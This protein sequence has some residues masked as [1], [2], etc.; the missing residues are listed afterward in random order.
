MV[1][2]IILALVCLY[3][4]TSE[5]V[6]AQGWRGIVP[7]HSTRQEVEALLGFKS[8]GEGYDQF[9]VSTDVVY[10]RYTSK[11]CEREEVGG[12]DVPIGTVSSI[13]VLPQSKVTF[14]SL[15]LDLNKFNVSRTD[16]KGLNIYTNKEDGFEVEMFEDE[17]I[18]AR[19]SYFPSAKDRRL[20]CPIQA[21]KSVSTHPC[22]NRNQALDL[23]GTYYFK[24]KLE[25]T[26]MQVFCITLDVQQRSGTFV[27]SGA[28]ISLAGTE[29]KYSE[30]A[31]SDNTF[32][33]TTEKVNDVQ[34]SFTG[35]WLTGDITAIENRPL[36]GAIILKGALKRMKSNKATNLDQ[37]LFTYRPE[38][39]DK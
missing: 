38:C 11:R 28:V 27:A 12:W 33:F 21:I 2:R 26:I 16:V 32:T 29:F 4:V 10:I 36:N 39:Y 35:K 7:L 13:I 18:V 19:F 30:V 8:S 31:V 9:K 23:S 15:G 22:P 6:M 37:I 20:Q 5:R 24:N 17:D 14:S 3:C 25:A 1:N 34:Y